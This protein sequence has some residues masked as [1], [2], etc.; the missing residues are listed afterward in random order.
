[1]EGIYHLV[2][3]L[4]AI[5]SKKLQ[6]QFCCLGISKGSLI[7][8]KHATPERTYNLSWKFH[9]MLELMRQP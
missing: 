5:P 2:A 1:M 4:A 8:Y 9:F 6:T 7:I 3:L